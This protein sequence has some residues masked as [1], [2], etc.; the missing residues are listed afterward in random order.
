MEQPF[1]YWSPRWHNLRRKVLARDNY[2]CT[3]CGIS[4]RG[5]GLSRVDHI[6][7]VKSRPDLAYDAA[8]LRT[9]C[10]SCDNMRH[11]EKGGKDKPAIGLDGLPDNW[12]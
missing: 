7:P 5:K 9:L 1:S 10:A 3:S 2:C 8:N 4:V 6:Q 12:R 11:A